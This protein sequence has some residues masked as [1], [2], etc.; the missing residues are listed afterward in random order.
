MKLR[1]KRVAALCCAGAMVFST[2]ACG[3]SKTATVGESTGAG[4]KAGTDAQSSA[5]GSDEPVTIKI[6]W[7]GGDAR[8]EYTQKLLD[9]YTESHPNVKFETS[10]SG[11]DGYFDKLSTQAA[12]GSM[13]DIVQMD[14][15]YI[16]TYAK[17]NSIADLNEFVDNGTIDVTNIED[18]ILNSG[19]INNKLAGLVLSTSAVT[20]G[21]NPDVLTAAG[22]EEPTSE[23]TWSDFAKMST[24]ISESTGNPSAMIS[25]GVVSDTTILNYWLRQHGQT[26]FKK[27]GTGLG[28]EADKVCAEFFQTFKDMIDANAYPDP[29]E[30]AQIL[31]LGQEAGPVVT[32]DAAYCFDWNNYSARVSTQNKNI[33]LV[34]PPLADGTT[35]SDAK[36]LWLKPGMFFSVSET[37]K[38]K[39]ACAEFINWFINSEEANEIIMAERGTP[40]SSSIR[41]YMINSGKMSSQ[42]VDMFKYVET[43]TKLAGETPAPEPS[44]IAEVNKAFSNAGNSVFYGQA[45]AEEAAASFRAEADEIL[46]RNNGK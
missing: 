39:Q 6:A 30:F 9:L 38:V 35:T 43:A 13:P 19:K 34:T 44:G 33:K 20:V 42:Q 24:K 25:A 26:L 12:S 31:T 37:S 46:L 1:L 45:T 27:D 18:A 36:G 3:N 41:E 40:V 32:G 21:Y 29:D 28:Y 11:W 14:Y 8:H 15:M 16:S 10:P 7:W 4:N 22:V 5:G 17:N 23:W 2:A